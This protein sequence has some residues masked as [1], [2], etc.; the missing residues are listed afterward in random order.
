MSMA[1]AQRLAA[2]STAAVSEGR[3]LQ[4]VLAAVRAAHPDLDA[5]ENGALQDISYGCQR[6]LGSLRFMLGKMT[7]KPISDAGLEGLLLAALYQLNYSRNAPHAVVNEAVANAGRIGRGRLRPF[8]NA[9]LR[10]FLR[11]REKLNA[12]CRNNEEAHYNFPQWWLEVLRQDYPKHWHNIVTAANARPPM[13]LRVN[14]RRN[15]AQGYAELLRGQG[16]QAEILDDCA[17]R[18]EHA[19]PVAGLPHFAEGMASV[20]DWGAQRAAALLA[21][22]DGERVLDA[23]AAPGGK[24]GHILETADCRLTAVDIDAERLR[25]VAD[26]L[27]RLGLGAEALHCADA[28]NLASWYDGVLFDAVLADVPCTASGVTKRNPDIKWLRRPGD[29]RKTARQQEGLL[30]ALWKVLKPQGRMLLA[31]CSLFYEE[32]GGQLQRF[33]NRHPDAVC[34]ATHTLLPNRNQDGFY[35]ALI[36]KQA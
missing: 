21:P 16:L 1:R 12:L 32:N 30:D 7:D 33:L 13:T 34:T 20:Q 9:V 35:Y 10:R 4:D 5:Q 19:V 8:A 3:N 31:T 29:A 24:S 36:R 6:Y 17:L 26:N 18:L 27:S 11:E 22:R 14:R 23:C 25:R 28:G 2:Q 15:T